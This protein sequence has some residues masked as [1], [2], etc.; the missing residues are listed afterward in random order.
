MF[1][2]VCVCVVCVYECLWQISFGFRLGRSFDSIS[3]KLDSIVVV[4]PNSAY[5]VGARSYAN[6]TIF[7]K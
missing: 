4:G 7:G 1:T 5:E 3:L 6:S 2:C